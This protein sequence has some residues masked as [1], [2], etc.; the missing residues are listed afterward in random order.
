MAEMSEINILEIARKVLRTEAS[1]IDRAYRKAEQR[2][3]GCC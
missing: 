2:F 3:S 1:A